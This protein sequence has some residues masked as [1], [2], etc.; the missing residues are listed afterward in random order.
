MNL[1]FFLIHPNE[2]LEKA[3]NL[4]NKNQK[5]IVLVIDKENSLVGTVT[6]GDIRRSILLGGN[7]ETPIKKIM[8]PNPIFLTKE[9][10]ELTIESVFLTSQLRQIPIIDENRKI[11]GLKFSEGESL[12]GL[13][14]VRPVIMAGG[15]GE[16]LYPMTNGTPKALLKVGEKTIIEGNII[17]LVKQGFGKITISTGHLGSKI[18]EKLGDGSKWNIQLDYIHEEKPL[19]TLGSLSMIKNF[20]EEAILVLNGDILTS[21]DFI[22]MVRFHE[23][24][25][26]D[27]S[28]AVRKVTAEIPFGIVKMSEDYSINS[29]VEKPSQEFYIN[30]GIYIINSNLVEKIKPNEFLDAPTFI[31]K[32]VLEKGFSIKAFL[33]TE[34]WLD[35]GRPEELKF[36]K[37]NFDRY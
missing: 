27:F 34:F 35:I 3:L 7:L 9:M 21:V 29:I 26:A 22:A 32:D 6:D 8:N 12:I 24:E 4:L 5:G 18:Q 1:K 37:K 13:P 25:K 15:K 30:A 14:T 16:R 36:A 33:I 31:K 28:I 11:F 17:N 20:S 19:G 2:Y 10:D 23:K